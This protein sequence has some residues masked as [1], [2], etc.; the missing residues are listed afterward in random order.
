MLKLLGTAVA[1]M[2]LAL[3]GSARA[4]TYLDKFDVVGG[5][6][7][8]V[9]NTPAHPRACVDG[10]CMNIS[11]ARLE[12]KESFTLLQRPWAV[13]YPQD[14]WATIILYAMN[15]GSGFD[16]TFYL[17]F[18]IDGVDYKTYFTIPA[19]QIVEEII[20][21]SIYAPDP[22][23]IGRW[24]IGSDGPYGPNIDR[25]YP[26]AQAIPE[27]ATWALLIVGFGLVGTGLR[28]ARQG[29]AALAA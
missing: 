28:R 3:A 10:P 18:V 6:V 2:T 9:T 24:L 26:S 4:T 11:G 25:I 5:S 13:P 29:Q 8:F 15:S 20:R 23:S 12:S 7:T 19:D 21:V 1:A 16:E 22:N 14:D 17:G 27:P